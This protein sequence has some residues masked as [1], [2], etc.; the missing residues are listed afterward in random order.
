MHEQHFVLIKAL[1]LFLFSF[2]LP[3]DYQVLQYWISCSNK[4][5]AQ[6]KVTESNYPKPGMNFCYFLLVLIGQSQLI[7]VT[8]ACNYFTGMLGAKPKEL[9]I[10]YF[11]VF[12]DFLYSCQKIIKHLDLFFKS[13]N[14]LLLMQKNPNPQMSLVSSKMHKCICLGFPSVPQ[15]MI[16]S[17][18]VSSHT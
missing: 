12:V 17:H 5:T 4:I 8:Q 16:P 11:G 15:Q 10:H 7:T 3:Q 13:V 2:I 9:S 18:R 6:C 14:L 1:K